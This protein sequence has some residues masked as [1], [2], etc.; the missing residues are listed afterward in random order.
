M[1]TIARIELFHVA[2]PLPAPFY[3][4][5]IP[6]FPQT[7]NRFT[8]IKVTTDDGVEGF[9]AGPALGN[10]RQGLGELLGPYLIGEDA[11]D[12]DLVQQRLRECAYLGWR[13]FWVEP[14]FFDIKGKLAGQPVCRLLGGEPRKVT[15]YAST[16]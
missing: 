14:A 1:S 3:P 10:E 13:N 9:S 8:L 16:G 4:S 12:I 7:E 5:W 2:I 11:T 6:G 15:L